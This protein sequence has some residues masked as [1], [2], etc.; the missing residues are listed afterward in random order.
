MNAYDALEFILAGATAI[1]VGTAN[2]R[3]KVTIKII[4]GI[5]DYLNKHNIQSI[6]ELIGCLQM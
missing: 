1:Q 2:F 3:S 4:K 5:E 6:R